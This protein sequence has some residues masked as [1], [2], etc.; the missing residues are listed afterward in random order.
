MV[1][2]LRVINPGS[3]PRVEVLGLRLVADCV[4]TWFLDRMHLKGQ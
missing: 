2:G 1:V 3:A 4:T